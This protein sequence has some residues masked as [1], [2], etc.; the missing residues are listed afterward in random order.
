MEQ[1]EIERVLEEL[2]N[3]RPDFLNAEAKRLFE[4]IMQIANERDSYKK[5]NQALKR[6]LEYYR[7]TAERDCD[8]EFEL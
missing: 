3:V 2:K 4:A 7:M 8:E 5:E 1:N 6:K